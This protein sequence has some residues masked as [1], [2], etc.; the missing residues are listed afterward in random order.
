M[1]VEKL[2]LTQDGVQEIADSLY[3]SRR[4]LQRHIASIYAKTDTKT[5]I[6]LFQSF[7]EFG[8]QEKRKEKFV[9]FYPKQDDFCGQNIK[10]ELN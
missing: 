2:L 3:I 9:Y 5:H 1:T 4:M 8:N 6:G 7:T 10:N